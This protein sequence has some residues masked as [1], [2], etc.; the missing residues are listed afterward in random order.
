[1]LDKTLLLKAVSDYEPYTKSQ[2]KMLKLL[3]NLSIDNHV[4][5]SC[6][7][8]MENLDLSRPTVYFNLKKFE[9][10]G[11]ITRINTMNKQDEFVLHPEKLE[12]I[13]KLYQIKLAMRN[14]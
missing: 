2:K 3:V 13:Y 14:D 6:N 4:T 5:I 11:F 9:R 1:M 8:I 12:Y 7:Y 10:D